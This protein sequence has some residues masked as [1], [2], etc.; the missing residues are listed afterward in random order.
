MLAVLVLFFI[1][2]VAPSE[3]ATAF[4]QNHT[5]HTRIVWEVV[6]IDNPTI[7]AEFNTAYR[8]EGCIVAV[9]GDELSLGIRMQGAKDTEVMETIHITKE[10][11][12]IQFVDI[13]DGMDAMIPIPGKFVYPGMGQFE[14]TCSPPARYLPKDVQRLFRGY[15]G[16]R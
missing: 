7:Q 10:G 4:D 14:E 3:G 6:K 11:A 9:K 13:T 15:G 16:I 5:R 12:T 2:F 8:W 1:F